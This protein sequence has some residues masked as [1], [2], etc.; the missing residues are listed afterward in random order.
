MIG[1]PGVVSSTLQIGSALSDG[2][3]SLTT[4]GGARLVAVYVVLQVI[5]Q[6]AINS[7]FATTLADQLP[8]EAM[9]TAYPLALDVPLAVSGVVTAIALVATILVSIVA[10]RAL[11]ADLDEVPNAQHTHRLPRTLAVLIVVSLI[12]GVAIGIGLIF[13][14]IPGIFLAVALVFTQLAVVVEEAGVVGAL[15]RSWSLTKGNRIRLFALGL[16]VAIVSGI[17]SALFGLLGVVSPAVG[18]LVSAAI[19]GVMSL[20]G[21]AVLVSAYQQITDSESA[22]M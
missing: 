1:Q 17:L 8:A 20:F 3:D 19:T 18:N 15:K 22:T 11:Y 12:T 14:V 9:N 4:R 6:V 10:M 21:L 2:I 7:L 13:L 16:I 5:T